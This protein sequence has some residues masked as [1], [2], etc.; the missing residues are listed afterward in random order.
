[1]IKTKFD[2]LF[3]IT[4]RKRSFPAKGSCTSIL[5]I[6]YNIPE[7]RKKP[8]SQGPGLNKNESVL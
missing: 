4:V 7:K 3:D 2:W 8:G 5:F 6:N 1:M